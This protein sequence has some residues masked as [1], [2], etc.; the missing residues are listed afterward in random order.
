MGI[1]LAISKTIVEA[2]GGE[3]HAGA[4]P[5]GGALFEFTLP[6]AAADSAP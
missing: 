2:H 1:G 4:H 6:I 3:M 5:G